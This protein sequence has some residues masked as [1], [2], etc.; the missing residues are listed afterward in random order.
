MNVFFTSDTHFSHENIIKYCNRPFNNATE[1][2]EKI[3]KNWNSVVSKN[4]VVYHLGDVHLGNPRL[5]GEILNRLNFSFMHVIKGNHEKSFCEWY[6]KNKPRNI[7]LHDSYLETKINDKR[8]TLCH[9]ALKVWNKSHFGAYHLYGHSHGTLS[10]D[11]HSLSFD[12]GVDCHEYFPISF[13]TVNEK[14]S[15]KDWK[16]IDHHENR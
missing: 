6:R 13:D 2:N 16:P 7:Y 14:M 12:V 3:I 15:Y 10:N 4:D 5:V 9:Y 1:M 11:K 8:F